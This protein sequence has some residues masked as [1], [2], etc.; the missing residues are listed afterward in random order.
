MTKP[1][2]NQLTYLM[3]RFFLVSTLFSAGFCHFAESK[4]KTSGI[5][6]DLKAVEE[7]YKKAQTLTAEFTQITEIAATQQ[8]KLTAGVVTLKQPN[9]IRW[10][11]LQPEKNLLVSDGKTFWSYDP[12]FEKGD[13]G[14]VITR[15]TSQ[16]QSR[17]ASILLSGEFSQAKDMGIE[18][19]TPGHY[20]LLPKKGS[21]GT[22]LRA[23]IDVN[24]TKKL[25]EKIMLEHEGGNHSTITL[26][27]IVLGEKIDDA[28]F[29]FVA[30]PDTDKVNQ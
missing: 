27:N 25:V 8:K 10:E 22:V 20:V 16:V 7:K 26:T 30:P 5:P 13:H 11:T 18:E 2:T 3:G 24:P 19:I 29:T 17:L 21:G 4:V 1:K 23:E 28:M 14:Q 6:A 9:K 12:P 15:K